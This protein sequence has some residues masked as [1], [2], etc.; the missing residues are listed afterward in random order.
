MHLNSPLAQ[1]HYR[2]SKVLK[3]FLVLEAIIPGAKQ[4]IEAVKAA[5]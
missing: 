3:G 4:S 1:K 2:K 5:H